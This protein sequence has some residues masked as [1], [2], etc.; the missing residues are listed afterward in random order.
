VE[1]AGVVVAFCL[2]VLLLAMEDRE[3]LVSL[4]IT[5]VLAFF[6]MFN[7]VFELL[8]FESVVSFVTVLVTTISF[9]V[10]ACDT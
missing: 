5:E 1:Q 2:T 10:V 4:R 3:L 6:D 9:N 8:V 7:E